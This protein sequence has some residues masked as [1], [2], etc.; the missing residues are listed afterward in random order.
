MIQNAKYF[1]YNNIDLSTFDGMRIGNEAN[2]LYAVQIIGNRVLREEKIPGRQSP[3]FY[4]IEDTPLSLNITVAL[5]R[6]KSIS[7]LRPFLR[8][9]YNVEDYKKLF[10]D[11]DPNKFYYA[12]FIG[13][14][15]FTYLDRSTSTDINNNNRKLIGF[16]NLTA[17]CN[18]ATA[19]GP[20]IETLK[21][22]PLYSSPF[23]I[24]NNG[25]NLVFPSL[26]IK[27][28]GASLPSPNT[29]L[30]IKVEN[31]SNGSYI[32]F[33]RIYPN[34][35]VTVDMSIKSID[36]TGSAVAHNIYES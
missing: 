33:V 25:D 22:N 5:D 3:Y 31:L 12:L 4:G 32:E 24:V 19:F 15:T 16:I 20:A 8:W 30:R 11:T 1:N 14:P 18:A 7:E 23:T 2:D 17:R 36:S 13:Q 29:F 10:F 27:M 21:V 26:T 6:P 34:E 35:E 9:L 28:G